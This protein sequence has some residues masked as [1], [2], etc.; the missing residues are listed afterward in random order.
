MPI[1]QKRQFKWPFS[2]RKGAQFYLSLRKWK[3]DQNGIKHPSECLKWEKTEN[4]VD[5]DLEKKE[6]SYSVDGNINL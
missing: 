4:P 6:C 1:L 2:I 3:F 5:Q